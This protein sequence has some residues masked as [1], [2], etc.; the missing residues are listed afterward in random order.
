MD[1]TA[2]I[3]CIIFGAGIVM[4]DRRYG[5]RTIRIAKSQLRKDAITEDLGYG[6]ISGQKPT[7]RF[8]VAPLG[9][10]I[11][12]W[13]ILGVLALHDVLI[14]AF[15]IFLGIL[16]EPVAETIWQYV[17]PWSRAFDQTVDS[18]EKGDLSAAS[19][20]TTFMDKMK[21]AW[22]GAPPA[23]QAPVA[24][25]AVSDPKEATNV[26]ATEAQPSSAA[27]L[28]KSAEEKAKE[29]FDKFVNG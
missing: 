27:A 24:K 18:L 8:I 25:S 23:R 20:P 9:L 4:L 10:A 12:L 1:W 5:M 19:V 7:I 26:T 13:Q 15:A 11:F 6:F 21:K 3:F 29:A 14:G 16:L 2:Y 22:N 17:I 28:E